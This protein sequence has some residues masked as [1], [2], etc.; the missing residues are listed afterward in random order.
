MRPGR[1]DGGPNEL[2]CRHR[3]IVVLA[4]RLLRAAQQRG[5]RPGEAGGALIVSKQR[6]AASDQRA[7]EGRR[8][9]AAPKWTAMVV[10]KGAGQAR[11]SPQPVHPVLSHGVIHAN[12]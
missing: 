7:I 3:E 6:S 11:S 12:L 10:R 8:V 4:S 1:R 2:L 9:V 5:V